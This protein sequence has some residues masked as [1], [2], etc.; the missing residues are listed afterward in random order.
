MDLDELIASVKKHF[1]ILFEE[2]GFTIWKA[3]TTGQ[4]DATMSVILK[5]GHRKV[6]ILSQMAVGLAFGIEDSDDQFL[7]SSPEDHWW[8][9][10]SLDAFLKKQTIAP[11]NFSAKVSDQGIA[12][13]AKRFESSLEEMIE[14]MKLPQNWQENFNEFYESEVKKLL[15]RKGI[16]E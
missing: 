14:M 11:W 3:F 1:A 16:Q 13:L 7:G 5:S 6:R 15:R 10:E 8:S 2:H 12:A 4:Y 9:A